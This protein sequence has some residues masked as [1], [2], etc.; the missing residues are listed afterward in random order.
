[1]EKV[2]LRI[3]RMM[4]R[5]L[6]FGGGSLTL[7]LPE[8]VA[9]LGLS[10]VIREVYSTGILQFWYFL[11][12]EHF[13]LPHVEFEDGLSISVLENKATQHLEI[14]KFL[15]EVKFSIESRIF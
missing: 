10:V 9:I 12:D 5:I 11:I 7:R 15:Q 8:S 3:Y 4:L 1:V 14:V 6:N 2:A 13:I